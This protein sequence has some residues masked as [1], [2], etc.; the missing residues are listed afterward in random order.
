[1]SKSKAIKLPITKIEW[2][3]IEVLEYLAREHIQFDIT[4]GNWKKE[5][6]AYHR[7][8]KK[9]LKAIKKEQ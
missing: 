9:Y 5:F 4:A 6:A 7:L 1:M 3:A 8:K 2:D